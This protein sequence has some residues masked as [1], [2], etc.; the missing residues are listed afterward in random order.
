MKKNPSK[1]KTILLRDNTALQLMLCREFITYNRFG[2]LQY[3]RISYSEI[4]SML[5]SNAINGEKKG[6]VISAYN[7]WIATQD[8]K[9]LAKKNLTKGKGGKGDEYK[10]IGIFYSDYTRLK[11]LTTYLTTKFL[12]KIEFSYVILMLL[13]KAGYFQDSLIIKLNQEIID[14]FLEWEKIRK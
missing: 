12:L 6:R 14:D 13:E 1:W 10:F 5:L 9:E 7:E 3:S 4:V 11:K 8:I 2:S